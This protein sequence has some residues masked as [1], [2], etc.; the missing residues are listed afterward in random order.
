MSVALV[1]RTPWP[2]SV[3]LRRLGWI[4]LRCLGRSGFVALVVGSW[5]PLPWSVGL[6]RLG[7][8]DSV[9]VWSDFVASVWS[10]S[11]TLVGRTP[12]SGLAGPCGRRAATSGKV[13]HGGLRCLG[14]PDR[15]VGAYLSS[16]G[17]RVVDLPI[18]ELIVD[19]RDKQSESKNLCWR[20]I[21]TIGLRG[22]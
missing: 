22:L 13:G 12:L 7:R 3:G 20:F 11:V 21:D 16:V 14:G 15:M 2:W 1:G 18:D 8:S 10:D 9:A 4:G 19:Q 5:T 17:C 6:R